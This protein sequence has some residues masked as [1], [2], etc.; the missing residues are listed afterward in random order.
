RIAVLA[1]PSFHDG[2]TRASVIA[3]SLSVAAVRPSTTRPRTGCAWRAPSVA[4]EPIAGVRSAAAIPS[5]SPPEKNGQKG[6]DA[7]NGEE[8]GHDGGDGDRHGTDAALGAQPN[9][10]LTM[11]DGGHRQRD[12]SRADHDEREH[13]RAEQALGPMRLELVDFDLEKL[14]EREP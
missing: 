1:A 6:E 10:A 8:R 13:A 12:E 9:H 4:V 11:L 5:L 3:Q 14:V 7:E 2:S